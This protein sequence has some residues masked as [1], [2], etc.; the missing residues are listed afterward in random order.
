MNR[1][2]PR[3]I[4]NNYQGAKLSLYFFYVVTLMTVVRSLIH[5]AAPD[6]GAQSIA[7]VPLDQY[8]QG[9]AASVISIF[10]LWGLSQLL[11]GILYVIVCFRYKALIPLMYV[12]L[13][14]EY[15]GRILVGLTKPLETSD[16]PPGA[17]LNMAFII[18]IPILGFLSLKKS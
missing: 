7:T 10:S 11:M 17:W 8:S 13:F 5:L 6:G 12:F 4:D 14:I 16:T 2:L 9:A 18:L 1:I 15:Q 3:V